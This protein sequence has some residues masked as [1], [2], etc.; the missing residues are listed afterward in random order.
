MPNQNAALNASRFH[1]GMLAIIGRSNSAVA[2]NHLAK[3]PSEVVDPSNPQAMIF[4]SPKGPVD[5]ASLRSFGAPA[6][7]GGRVLAGNPQ[8]SGRIDYIQDNMTAGVF[9]VTTGKVEITFPFTEHA[10]ILEGEV[11]LTDE[12]GQTRTLK[13]GDSYFVRQNQV[14]TCEVKGKQLI[15][16]F[17]NVVNP[18]P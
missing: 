4:Y 11:I 10:T 9:M 7:L 3:K 13:A 18:A 17:F 5:T 2:E 15:K 14:V 6:D 1:S 8:I 12:A 16:S